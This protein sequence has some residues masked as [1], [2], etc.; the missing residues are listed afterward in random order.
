MTKPID[1]IFHMPFGSVGRLPMFPNTAA[2]LGTVR[3]I[4]A[5]APNR[6]LLVN[7]V[8]G[9]IHPVIECGDSFDREAR[10]LRRAVDPHVRGDV[11]PPFQR[12]VT[13]IGHLQTLVRYVFEQQ[14]AHGL[15][16]DPAL[17]PGSSFQDLA[18]A[19]HL[20]ALGSALTRW[21]PRLDLADVYA[22]VGLPRLYDAVSIA[23]CVDPRVHPR[24]PGATCARAAFVQLTSR[25]DFSEQAIRE[26]LS[27][28]RR[29]VSRLRQMPTPEPIVTAARTRIAL[30]D[31]VVAARQRQALERMIAEI[32]ARK[33]RQG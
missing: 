33:R 1:R 19:R 28:S 9:H 16:I 24:A 3:G 20:P 27:I 5:C 31:F 30:E 23:A 14:P 2:V 11:E 15:A 26:A 13:S 6:V 21:L 17:W 7:A 22:I 8:P 25:L 4:S 32:A 10:R 18:G 29:S 12:A